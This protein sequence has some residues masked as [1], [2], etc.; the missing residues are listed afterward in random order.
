MWQAKPAA[1]P[2]AAM[3]LE[4]TSQVAK[5]CGYKDTKHMAG[6]QCRHAYCSHSK[7]DNFKG[8]KSFCKCR[9]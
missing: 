8:Y 9:Q 5:I 7:Q 4:M 6:N 2:V 3:S 1:R